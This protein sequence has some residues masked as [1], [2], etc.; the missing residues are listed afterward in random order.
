MPKLYY[1]LNSLC[2]ICH[3]RA[4]VS[5]VKNYSKGGGYDLMI[6]QLEIIQKCRGMLFFSLVFD[7]QSF[8]HINVFDILTLYIIIN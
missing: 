5:I 4:R 7:F 8:N 1:K 3:G 6:Q 2:I